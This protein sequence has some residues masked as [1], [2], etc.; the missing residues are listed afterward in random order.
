MPAA[1]GPATSVDVTLGARSG[2]HRLRRARDPIKTDFILGRR[3]GHAAINTLRLT[4]LA[5]DRPVLSLPVKWEG[6]LM[7]FRIAL[8]GLLL[9]AV[10]IGGA[11]YTLSSAQPAKQAAPASTGPP[12]RPVVAAGR[13]SRDVPSFLRARRPRH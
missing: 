8:A 1:D 12:P 7:R 5:P 9:T 6:I 11:A 13:Q 2:T 10:L 3:R 4:I